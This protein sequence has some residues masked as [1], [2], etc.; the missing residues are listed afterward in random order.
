MFFLQP[1]VRG[2][3]RYKSRLNTGATPAKT[4]RET[5]QKFLTWKFSD[6]ICFWSTNGTDRYT[7]LKAVLENLQKQNYGTKLDNGWTSHD[8]EIYTNRWAWLRLTTAVE[9]LGNGKLF[10][11]CR[12]RTGW[13]LL[14]KTFFGIFSL[15]LLLVVIWLAPIQ[16]WIWMAWTI[17]PLLVWV[18]ENKQSSLQ[19]N[20]ATVL[21]AAANETGLQT[22]EG[23][24]ID[25]SEV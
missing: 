21:R 9:E 1:I 11:R 25:L 15:A 23:L 3:A 2:W 6:T 18:I 5:T 19:M 24:G 12:L 20:I 17:L 7:F 22:Y 13:S 14:A 16:H 8:L 4:N 10:L